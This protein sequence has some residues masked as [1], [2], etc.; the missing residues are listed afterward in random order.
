MKSD[1][2]TDQVAGEEETEPQTKKKSGR[3]KKR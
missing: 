1:S 3:G 2:Q